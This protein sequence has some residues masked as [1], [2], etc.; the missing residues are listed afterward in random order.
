[1]QTSTIAIDPGNFAIKVADGE[2]PRTIRS[3]QYRLPQGVNPLKMLKNSPLIELEDGTR[4]HVGHQAFKYASQEQTVFQD[5]AKLARLHFYAAIAQPKGDFRLIVSHHSPQVYASLLTKQLLGIHSFRRNGIPFEVNVSSVEVVPEGQGIYWAGQQAGFVPNS[6]YTIVL[7]LGGSSWL[8]R[9]FDSEGDIIAEEVGDRF[10]SY[11]LAKQITA[12][13]RLKKPLR[14]IGITSPDPG[15][16]LDGFT[17]GHVYAET[18]ISW[19]DWFSEYLDPWFK[20]IVGGMQT[21]CT[22]HLPNT[23]R[24]LVAGGGA[25]LVQSKILGLRQSPFEVLPQPD[26]A[27]VLGMYAAA[28]S[29]IQVKAA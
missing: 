4:Y 11:H 12:D 29:N 3:V 24:F 14:S 26:F 18:G 28:V 1:M 10:G 21:A 15:V 20:T 25:Y 27:G 5:K 8:Y 17:R 13:D 19:K 9:V 2:P 6:G 22:T 7:D 16:V 23:R